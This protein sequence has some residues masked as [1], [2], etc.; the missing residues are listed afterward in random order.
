MHWQSIPWEDWVRSLGRSSWALLLFVA[1][2]VVNQATQE[3]SRRRTRRDRLADEADGRQRSTRDEI[4]ESLL[5]QFRLAGLLR[6]EKL[7]RQPLNQAHYDEFRDESLRARMLSSR[8]DGQ[9]LIDQVDD[10]RSLLQAAV[11]G[12]PGGEELMRLDYY[13][14]DTKKSFDDLLFE[15]T[16][17]IFVAL[18]GSV[19]SEPMIVPLHRRP[20][21]VLKGE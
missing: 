20:D 13:G 17:Q 11:S 16:Q 9:Q 5:V 12:D 1:G 21:F 10:L 6:A 18:G 14:L 2:L 3:W 19:T 15:F 7:S 4:Q 8:L